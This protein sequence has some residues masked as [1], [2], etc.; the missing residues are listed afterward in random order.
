MQFKI[1]TWNKIFTRNTERTAKI[2]R[3]KVSSKD[4]KEEKVL[5]F[6]NNR[7]HKVLFSVEE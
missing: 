3:D 4:R 5:I 7:E 6:V 2:K 1:I